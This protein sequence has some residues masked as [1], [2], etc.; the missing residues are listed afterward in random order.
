[1]T[2]E[3][4]NSN[5]QSIDHK[6]AVVNDTAFLRWI[7]DTTVQTWLPDSIDWKQIENILRKA[8]ADSMFTFL[9][10]PT[11]ESMRIHYYRQYA[12]YK[13]INSQKMVYLNAFC[14]LIEYPIETDDGIVME[15][16]DWENEIIDVEDGGLCYWQ[17]KIDL[18]TNS[19]FDFKTNAGG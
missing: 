5:Q 14:E 11:L 6:I 17:L 16:W 7:T 15:L 9:K 3:S 1:M 8:E 18:E 10:V 4:S 12:F 13:T 2:H 19:Y